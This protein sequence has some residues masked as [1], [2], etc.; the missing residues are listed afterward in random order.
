MFFSDVNI[1]RKKN[2]LNVKILTGKRTY[3]ILPSFF[4]FIVFVLAKLVIGEKKKTKS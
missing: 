4:L 3:K 1:K 2:P